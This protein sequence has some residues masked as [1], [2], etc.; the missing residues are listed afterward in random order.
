LG[1]ELSPSDITFIAFGV[2]PVRCQYT[3]V[4]WSEIKAT[5]EEIRQ[6]RAMGTPKDKWENRGLIF[7][8]AELRSIARYVAKNRTRWDSYGLAAVVL[9]LAQL[10]GKEDQIQDAFRKAQGEG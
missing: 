4:G 9:G 1:I 8:P 5:A 6:R 10:Q 2:D 3:F 7:V